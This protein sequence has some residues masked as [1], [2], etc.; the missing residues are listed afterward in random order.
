MGGPYLSSGLIRCPRW[1]NIRHELE[2]LAASRW[3]DLAYMLGGWSN[4]RKDG[5]L[6]KWT[7]SKAVI[8]AGIDFAIDT[9][10]L[11]CCSNEYGEETEVESNRGE[12]EDT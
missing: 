10:R 12:E 4:E 3:G 8:S 5:P 9:S 7:P 11:E 1:S 6:D 2:R